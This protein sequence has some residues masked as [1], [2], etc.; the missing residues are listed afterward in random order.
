MK[1]EQNLKRV[2]F[3]EC[4]RVFITPISMDD[5]DD[6]YRWD[7]DRE[8]TYLDDRYFRAR[9]Y[10]KAKK[11]FEDRINRDDVMAFSIISNETGENA[12]VVELYDIDY[13]ER[14]C[15][16]G[17][18]LD[19]KFWKQ[20]IGEE[21]ARKMIKYVFD[22]LGFR[23]LKSYTHSGNEVSMRFQERLGFIREA[24]LR[25]EYSFSGEYVDGIDYGMLR[26]EYD[27]AFSTSR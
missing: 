9:P 24:V 2:R 18:V 13:Y 17:I 16:W 15:Y 19:K 27:S 10:E 21:T 12:G 7:H 11:V 14:K 25:Q 23:R 3:L 1:N 22:D 4:E 26:E 6:H 20:G 5:F 8:I